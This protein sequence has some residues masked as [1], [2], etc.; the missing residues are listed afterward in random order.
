MSTYIKV[1]GTTTS[2]TGLISMIGNGIGSHLCD[3]RSYISSFTTSP[4]VNDSYDQT[5]DTYS[6]T[7][8]PGS[9]FTMSSNFM[10]GRPGT[11]T[12]NL[13]LITNF[14]NDAFKFTSGNI[15]LGNCSFLDNAFQ[16]SSGSNTLG[17]CTFTIDAFFG[18][19]GNNSLG[20]CIFG[21]F[22]FSG[23]YLGN[24]TLGSCNFGSNC[25][26]N[27]TGNHII[28]NIF[29]AGLFFGNMFYGVMNI[30]GNIGLTE[31]AD[32]SLFFQSSFAA[33]INALT[34]K[35]TS[36]SGGLEGDLANAL[37]NGASVNCVL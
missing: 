36:N 27:S 12:D 20:D 29:G 25:F 24:S 10:I 1:G 5:T 6:F 23:G 22:A 4:I 11:F 30:Y 8:Q 15:T 32:L 26:E 18:A 19:S 35:A 2:P 21:D 14:G 28:L 3:Y 17:N 31:N 7:V 9:L 37:A 13:G 33:T 16:G 34:F